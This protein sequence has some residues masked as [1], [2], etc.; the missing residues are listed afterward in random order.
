MTHTAS[1]PGGRDMHREITAT[2]IAAI[3]KGA[4]R[5]RMA[6]FDATALAMTYYFFENKKR[7]AA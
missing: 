1:A 2:I 6:I 5:V 7:Q 3:E 4:C